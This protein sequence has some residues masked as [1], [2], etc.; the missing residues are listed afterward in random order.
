MKTLLA[1]INS[2]YI[3]SC[4]AVW[5]LRAVCDEECGEVLV[6]EWNINQQ[7]LHIYGEILQIRPNAVAFSCYIWNIETVLKLA[8]DLKTAMPELKIILGGPEVSF[9]SE[10]LLK[11][12]PFIDMIFLGEAE[13]SLPAA[14]RAMNR[15]EPINCIP[16]IAARGCAP[17]G[18]YQFVENFASL[19]SPYTDEML[20]RTEGKI[21]YYESSRGCPF[22]CAYCLSQIGSGVRE[23]PLERVIKELDFLSSRGIP[24][25]KFVDRTFN[26]N[27][28]RAA[29]L[30]EYIAS[31]KG[32][33]LYHFEI[34]GDLLGEKQLSILKQLPPGNVQFEIGVQSTNPEVLTNVCR[35]TDWK[36]LT[37]N[38]RKLIGF[39]NIHIHLDL[40]A[41]LPG[42]DYQ[43]FRTS[44]NDVY[45]LEPH[46]LQLGFLKLLK[47]S[48]LRN[49]AE[50]NACR[51]RSYPPYEVLTTR[52]LSAEELIRLK[53]VEEM[54]DRY[55]NSRRFNTAVKM[56]CSEFDS[57]FKLYTELWSFHEK[58][59][60]AHRPLSTAAQYGLL[61]DFAKLVFSAADFSR[62][63][64]CLRFDYFSAGLKGKTPE[65]LCVSESAEKKTL[66][67]LLETDGFKALGLAQPEGAKEMHRRYRLISFTEEPVHGGKPYFVIFDAM[68]K[69]P[70]TGLLHSVRFHEDK[71]E[72]R[73]GEEA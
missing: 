37:E 26:C 55:Y 42:E 72:A 50:E 43:S 59:G 15:G 2:Q 48:R 6:G 49:E 61:S 65:C 17:C 12:H 19:P 69:H 29:A 23:K 32:N 60:A 47:G 22:N 39:K 30:W 40:I 68:Q 54:L 14:L 13:I 63:T 35:K 41:G 7:L 71:T 1:A 33:T 27:H 10:A 28:E 16:G 5:Q 9:D 21:I 45:A 20:R 62:F 11:G 18:G 58:T 52:E 73:Q 66:N 51:Y 38:V 24:L 4:L 53:G 70:V 36:R 64:E 31:K 56:L 3:H 67:R 25:I 34:G 8:R 44:F 46:A 57:P